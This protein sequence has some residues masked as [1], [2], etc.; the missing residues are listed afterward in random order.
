MKHKFSYINRLAKQ[1]LTANLLKLQGRQQ[2]NE[3]LLLGSNHGKQIVGM[4]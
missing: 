4:Y 2:L 3:L 1:G